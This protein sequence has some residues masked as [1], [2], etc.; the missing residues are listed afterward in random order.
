MAFLDWKDS[1]NLGI[2]EIDNQH[3]GLFDLISRLSNTKHYEHGDKYFAATLQTLLKY[4]EVHFATEERYMKEA[5]Y[6]KLTE[7]QQEHAIF[8]YTLSKL[9]KD[10]ENNDPDLHTKIL[11]FLHD[12]YSSHILG[13]DREI[14]DALKAK[15]FS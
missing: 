4:A 1:Y 13:T 14:G 9:T 15:G 10:L 2:K 5:Q 3:Q 6:P 11:N 8:L 7:H 12:W